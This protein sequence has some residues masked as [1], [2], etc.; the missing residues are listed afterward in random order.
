MKQ[1]VWVGAIL[2]LV[3]TCPATAVAETFR[4]NGYNINLDARQQGD[5]LELSGRID[6]GAP[7]HRLAIGLTLRNEAG[8]KKTTELVVNNAGGIYS[9]LLEGSLTVK[10]AATPWSIGKVAV[11]CEEP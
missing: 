5:R 3:T 4:K 11:T 6:G 1:M 10:T 9:R 2:A 8:T 7:C